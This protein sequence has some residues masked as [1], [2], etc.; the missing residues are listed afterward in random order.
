MSTASQNHDAALRA[1]IW[2]ALQGKLRAAGYGPETTPL[3]W[4]DFKDAVEGAAPTDDV[5]PVTAP[6]EPLDNVPY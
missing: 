6:E 3:L 5:P 4:N 2:E 1:A